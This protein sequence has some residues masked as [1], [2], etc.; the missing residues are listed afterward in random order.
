MRTTATTGAAQIL[1]ASDE[2]LDRILCEAIDAGACDGL[3]GEIQAGYDAAAFAEVFD[4]YFHE[5]D[6]YLRR[7]LETRTHI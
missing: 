1:A 7:S 2:E 6:A 3:I 4:P 5:L